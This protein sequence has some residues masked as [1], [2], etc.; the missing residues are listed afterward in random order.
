[1]SRGYGN[2]GDRLQAVETALDRDDAFVWIDLIS[3]TQDEEAEIEARL[4][5]DL[6][7]RED[8][9]EIEI[10]SRLYQDSGAVFMTAN[11][12]AQTDEDHP[13]MAPFTFIM[14]GQ[15]PVTVRFHAARKRPRMD[16]SNKFYT[17]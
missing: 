2:R 6:P 4:G 15:R 11:L 5:I 12:P 3:P 13:V 7:S 8:M 10:S 9:E 14:A 16:Y 17:R 1:M